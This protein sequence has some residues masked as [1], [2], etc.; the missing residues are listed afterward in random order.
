M[1]VVLERNCNVTIENGRIKTSNPATMKR[2]NNTV[3]ITGLGGVSGMIAT[4]VI[5]NG[6]D[7]V[8]TEPFVD[9]LC[10]L[11]NI[12][13]Q[14]AFT[15]MVI[16]MQD[17]RYVSDRQKRIVFSWLYLQSMKCKINGDKNI[18]VPDMS[19]N[20]TPDEEVPS[21]VELQSYII[22]MLDLN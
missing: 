3:T 21:W 17:L 22:E 4:D 12:H 10:N 13:Q 20:D 7:E 5:I 11:H 2:N 9:V 16:A 6:F 19:I 14:A 1:K 18:K 8:N 15:N